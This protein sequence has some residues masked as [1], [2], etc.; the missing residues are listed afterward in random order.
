MDPDALARLPDHAAENRRHWNADA[1]NWVASGERSWA[2]AEPTWGMWGVP[3]AD[4]GMFDGLEPGMRTIELGCGTGYLHRTDWTQVPVDPGGIEFTPPLS[5]WFERFGAIGFDVLDLRE[6][7][8][9]SDERG[10]RFF[11]DAAWARNWPSE[12]VWKLRKRS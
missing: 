2:Q 3:E 10:T 1:A 12:L 6:P 9:A 7:R 4:V 11:V 8:P 5:G